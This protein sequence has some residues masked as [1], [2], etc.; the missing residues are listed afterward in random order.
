MS[1]TIGQHTDIKL[2]LFN[3]ELTA[4]VDTGATTCCLHG[5]NIK[6]NAAQNSVTFLNSDLSSNVINM[7]LKGEVDVHSADNGAD[8]RPIVELDVV[9]NG[10]V[11]S[12]VEF[13]INDRSQMDTA[14]LIGQNLLKQ[15]GFV[16]DVAEAEN[17]DVENVPPEVV[18]PSPVQMNNTPPSGNIT[19]DP[20]TETFTLILTKQC[21]LDL[22]ATTERS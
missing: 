10:Q 11:I 5:T 20:A 21:M 3:K 16:V 14:V 6:V 4:K 1:T 18:D 15:G 7:S 17:V 13:N 8:K 12:K 22:I 9:I 2:P 19:Y